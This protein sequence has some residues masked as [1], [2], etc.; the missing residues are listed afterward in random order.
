M[1]ANQSK[2]LDFP[3]VPDGIQFN[4]PTLFIGGSNSHYLKNTKINA[5]ISI[6]TTDKVKMHF[7][8]SEIVFLEGGHHVYAQQPKEFVSRLIKFWKEIK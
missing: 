7:P 2:V 5:N 8:N 1:H 3:A 6:S 4:G